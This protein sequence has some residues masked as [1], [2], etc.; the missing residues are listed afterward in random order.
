[1]EEVLRFLKE[2]KTFYLATVDGGQPRVRPFG[3]V[4]LH[5]GKLY[6]ITSNQKKVFKQLSANPK[7][8]ISAMDSK[9]AWIRLEAT[10]VLG[11]FRE[12]K[13]QMLKSIPT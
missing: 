4:I 9:G 10:A 5:D 8:E 11:H 12:A 1:M 13:V 3:A 2:A 7:L 6:F